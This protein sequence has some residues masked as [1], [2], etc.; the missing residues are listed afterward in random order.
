MALG[1]G[2][3]QDEG[4]AGAIPP[5][6]GSPDGIGGSRAARLARIMELL[7][8]EEAHTTTI[9]AQRATREDESSETYETLR[10]LSTDVGQHLAYLQTMWHDTLRESMTMSD[11]A[12]ASLQTTV[13]LLAKAVT[14]LEAEVRRLA[15]AQDAT[16]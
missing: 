13:G 15:A 7:R 14:E 4:V 9:L 10:S 16:G 5:D 1:P 6:P 8:E 12:I 2:D 11:A 3:C